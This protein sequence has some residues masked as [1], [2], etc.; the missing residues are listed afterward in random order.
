[1]LNERGE[2]RP[3]RATLSKVAS[4]AGVSTSTVSLVLSGK[5]DQGRI[6]TETRERVELAANQLNY[7]PNILTRSL[8]K[9]RTKVLSYFSAF[10]NRNWGDLYMD[11]ISSAVETA[12]GACQYDILVHCNFQRSLKETY[13]FLNGGIAEGLLL[14]APSPEDP[15]LELLRRSSLPVVLIHGRDK[16]G[17]Y[18]S[19]SDDVYQGMALVA[20]Q[21]FEHGHRR[22]G[23]IGSIGPDVRDSEIRLK[24][25]A[26]E[27]LSYGIVL[28]PDYVGWVEEDPRAEV[29]RL[30]ELPQP[31]TAIFCWRDLLAYR[32]L[33]VCDDLGISVPNQLSIVGYDGVHWPSTSKHLCASVVVDLNAIALAAVQAMDNILLTDTPERTHQ[34]IPVSFQTGTTLCHYHPDAMEQL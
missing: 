27:L 25:L 31:P 19:V 17:Q 22:I 21:L 20:K 24:L 14:F 30:M 3:E 23:A 6:P 16:L 33:E 11:R 8:R 26:S 10:R 34:L 12:G 29:A 15:L 9:G 2:R 28:D 1:M 5:A 13:Q 4:L 18:S 7:A 32:A